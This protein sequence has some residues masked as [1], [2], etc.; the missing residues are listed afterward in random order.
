MW[1]LSPSNGLR[2][3]ALVAYGAGFIAYAAALRDIP[4]GSGYLIMT[5]TTL[6]VTLAA[7]WLF[8]HERLTMQQLVGAA[9]VLLGVYLVIPKVAH[10]G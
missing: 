6:L 8:L 1:Q 9:I 4:A 2:L 7:S 10:G 5:A 3:L